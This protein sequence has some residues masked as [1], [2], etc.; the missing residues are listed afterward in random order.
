MKA[1]WPA[2]AVTASGELNDMTLESKATIILG[3]AGSVGF[4]IRTGSD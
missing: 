4:R 1:A 2:I 3:T